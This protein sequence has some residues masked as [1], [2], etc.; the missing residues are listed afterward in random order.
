MLRLGTG[1]HN[2]GLPDHGDAAV[3]AL[4]CPGAGNGRRRGKV[5]SCAAR[6]FHC[7]ARL[8]LA[9]IFVVIGHIFR[10]LQGNC[11]ECRFPRQ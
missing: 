6:D 5:E 9:R 1:R 7:A 4:G 8:T 3:H 10:K 2:D 11:A